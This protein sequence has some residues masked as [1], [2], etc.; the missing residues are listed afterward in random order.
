MR[1]RASLLKQGWQS[2]ASSTSLLLRHALT[3]SAVLPQLLHVVPSGACVRGAKC[4]VKQ[5]Q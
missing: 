3:W 1:T 2:S 5:E 4:D